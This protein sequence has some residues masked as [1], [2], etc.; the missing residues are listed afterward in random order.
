MNRHS[1]NISIY[2]GKRR[3]VIFSNQAESQLQHIMKNDR[4][5][6]EFYGV[7]SGRDQSDE[8]AFSSI[9]KCIIEVL[10]VDVR[11]R[12]QT[13]KVRKGK[14]KAER[15]DRV[16]TLANTNAIVE[17]ENWKNDGI[18]TQQIDR[19]L[20]KYTVIE[21]NH[22]NMTSVVDTNGSGADDK[23]EILA[24]ELMKK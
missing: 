6:L 15:T 20:I 11:S 12:F 22:H 5:A 4:D 18:C 13:K 24:I 3:Q 23:V 14:F 2:L 10:G 21:S 7:H 19:L 16:Q 9:K 17:S 8:Q 1:P